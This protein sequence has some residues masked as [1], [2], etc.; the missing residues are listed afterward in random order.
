MD[1]IYAQSMAHV[2]DAMPFTNLARMR[3]PYA[4]SGLPSFCKG[5]SAWKEHSAL[6]WQGDGDRDTTLHGRL[7]FIEAHVTIQWQESLRM[8]SRQVRCFAAAALQCQH[9]RSLCSVSAWTELKPRPPEMQPPLRPQM[10]FLT[11]RLHASWLQSCMLMLTAMHMCSCL[12]L[13]IRCDQS[14]RPVAHQLSCQRLGA[15]PVPLE[16]ST[17]DKAQALFMAADLWRRL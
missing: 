6:A 16:A 4:L 3:R 13:R 2:G 7:A 12:A 17:M 15:T 11:P 5:R 9:R 10:K 14:G 8:R 1:P